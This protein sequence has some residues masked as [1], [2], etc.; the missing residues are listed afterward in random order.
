MT[1]SN[2]MHYIYDEI[3]ENILLEHRIGEKYCAAF[4][5]HN[6]YEIYLFLQGDINLLVEH[7]CVH[8]ER[9]ALAIMNPTEYHLAVSL[10]GGLYERYT[11][12]LNSNFLRSLSTSK[13][14]FISFFNKRIPGQNN[15]VILPEED[16]Q[17]ILG[18]YVSLKQA[19]GNVTFC[20]DIL[21]NSYCMQILYFV[22]NRFIEAK[23]IPENI[24]PPL[25][26]RTI[27]YIND[28]IDKPLTLAELENELSYNRDYISKQFKQY[29]GMSIK[30]YILEK[31]IALAESL[32]ATGQ[33]VT[34]VCYNTGFNDYANFIRTFKKYTG[35]T[36]K[37][38][39]F[40]S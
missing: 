37:Q 29:T 35:H 36:P 24:M 27:Q 38:S 21:A 31:K 32:L 15:I 12:N 3:K 1:E 25:I 23:N 22:C 34:D 40:D 17:T 16:I 4:H 6:G 26:T 10:D 9:G 30:K 18:L 28:N 39:K 13:T 20:S 2:N 11:L 33:S 19:L 7:S 8:L 14:N 5:K